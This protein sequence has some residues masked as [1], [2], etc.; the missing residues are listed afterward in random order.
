M[1]EFAA[2]TW[3][4]AVEV[5]VGA[6]YGEHGGRIGKYANQIAHRGIT[7]RLGGAERQADHGAQVVLELTRLGA[8]DGPMAGVM[9]ARRDLIGDQSSCLARTLHLEKLHRQNADI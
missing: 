5:Q 9:D 6:R 4:L 8:L 2:G 7:T 3:R 1:A